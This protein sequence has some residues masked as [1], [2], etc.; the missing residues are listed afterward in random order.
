MRSVARWALH[1]R[2]NV[3]EDSIFTARANLEVP[4]IADTGRGLLE[5]P[6]DSLVSVAS[7]GCFVYGVGHSSGRL[8]CPVRA[9]H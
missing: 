2:L 9:G 8:S 4:G 6:W 5:D 3:L 7:A 1:G